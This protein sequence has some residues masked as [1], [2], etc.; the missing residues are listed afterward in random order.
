MAWREINSHGDKLHTLEG[1]RGLDDDV[2]DAKEPVEADV[3]G[4][5]ARTGED[6]RVLPVLETAA[7][8]KPV[9]QTTSRDRIRN[10]HSPGSQYGRVGGL[11]RGQSRGR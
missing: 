1:E 8:Q 9:P 3:R 6:T 4:L 5:Q 2:Q 7:H 11:L 10:A